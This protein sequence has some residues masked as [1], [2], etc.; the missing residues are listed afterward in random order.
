MGISLIDSFTGSGYLD[1]HTSDSGNTWAK[2]NSTVVVDTISVSGIAAYDNAGSS[3]GKEY[4]SN[5]TSAGTDCRA[6]VIVNIGTISGNP[7][8]GMW[9]RLVNAGAS[10]TTTAG[11]MGRYVHGSGYQFY[12]ILNDTFTQ[13]GSTVAGTAP[14]TGQTLE[15]TVQ[16]TSSPTLTLYLNGT[17]QNT[18]N[19]TTNAVITAGNA[20]VHLYS[21]GGGAT[22]NYTA[23]AIWAG[24][25]A[26]PTLSCTTALTALTTGESTTATASG[27]SGQLTSPSYAP[28]FTSSNTAV[29]TVNSSTGAVLA[30]GAGTCTITAT[31]GLFTI[32]T[33]MSATITVTSSFLLD[34]FT[35]STA[36]IEAHTSDSEHTWA[37]INSTLVVDGVTVAN[38]AAYDNAGSSGGKEYGSSFVASSANA[39]VRIL[40]GAGT[41]SGNAEIGGWLRLQNA[42]ASSTTTTGYLGRYSTT[43]G[44]YQF[45]YIS[46]DTFTLIGEATGSAPTNGS[47]LD[48]TVNGT[49]GPV[50]TLYVNGTQ[51]AQATDSNSYVTAAGTIGL[52]LYNPGGTEA[53]NYR[54][55][56]IWGGAL[57]GPTLSCSVGSTSLQVGG[58]T[59]TATASGFSGQVTSPSYAPTF[60]SS[61]TA[62][63]TVNSATGV[64][65]PVGAGTC[66]ITAA[67]GLFTT[68]ETATS[69][70]ITVTV[71]TAT[72]FTLTGPSTGTVGTASSNFT[73]TPNG[74]YTGTITPTMTGLAGTWSPTTLTWS[75]TN[76]AQTATFTA[77][78]AGMGTANGTPSPS[79]TAPSSISY[80][81]TATTATTFTL[82]GPSSGN[83]GSASA[84]FTYTPNAS[85]TGTITPTMAGLTG[86]WNPSV[87]TWSNTSTAQ[88][89]QFT[90]SSAGTGAANGSPSPSLTT[91]ISVPYA[92]I[93]PATGT[94]LSLSSV[95]GGIGLPVTLTVGGNGYWTGTKTATFSDGGM[96][97][98]FSA[99][100]PLA[101]GTTGTVTY[102]PVVAG[103]PTLTAMLSG[104][105][106]A[107]QPYLVFSAIYCLSGV[108]GFPANLLAQSGFGYQ[109]S[110]NGGSSFGTLVTSGITQP[111]PGSYSALIAVTTGSLVSVLWTSG[112][113][114]QACDNNPQ[115]ISN[116]STVVSANVAEWND[117]PVGAYYG[118]YKTGIAAGFE[119]SMYLTGTTLPYTG[120]AVSVVKSVAGAAETIA[121]GSVIQIGS[122]N[123]YYFAGT[124]S[125]F[126][127][128]FIG[129]CFSAAGAD[130]VT[131]SIATTP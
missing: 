95:S 63:A 49:S 110:T 77:S 69:P 78:V 9:L 57:A 39:R 41:I 128:A 127:G 90:P 56:A 121:Q 3:G 102:T 112:T 27:F 73:Y 61:N 51:V 97:G 93:G 67:G 34:S 36:Y 129:F 24:P 53:N 48:F 12:S 126:T 113:G 85:Y 44:G 87:L 107:S 76:T 4:G 50:L 86:A 122:S 89:S 2:I 64:V 52:H 103:T 23:G 58:A 10:S 88:T 91:P 31:G 118:P 115:F 109:V 117:L 21:P 13:I 8:I 116:T 26:G 16:G 20:G 46:N 74:S 80:T 98:T 33:A 65:T 99:W 43:Y 37:K 124:A 84:N 45:Y 35:G 59:T 66:T 1:A 104:L 47:Y 55:Q 5:W 94:T 14:T 11:Y 38:A 111:C 15:F 17:Q 92:S 130:A 101:S 25:L 62:V 18:A 60:T 119:F 32:E 6:R 105:A 75:G 40:V 106:P 125:D 22:N 114:L 19:D 42:S 81:A 100:T 68:A 108:S 30:V 83:E 96:G 71:A 123:R 29:C 72:A 7:E 70:T 120:G 131:I 79:L 82:T 54:A 28:T